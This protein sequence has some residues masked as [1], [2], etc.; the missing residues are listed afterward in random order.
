MDDRRKSAIP[1]RATSMSLLMNGAGSIVSPR[2]TTT[3]IKSFN[4]KRLS[5]AATA[6]PSKRVPTRAPES[7]LNQP[8][9]RQSL[10][11]PRIL[12]AYGLKSNCNNTVNMTV[13]KAV[14]KD[15]QERIK[16]CVRKRPTDFGEREI[17][18]LDTREQSVTVEC[19]KMG[20][21]GYSKSNGQMK[22][23]FDHVFDDRS[24]NETVPIRE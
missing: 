14:R 10:A 20:L 12:N 19:T 18:Q 24:S 23:F 16:V 8:A 3:T 2:K 4:V 9:R 11:T 17:V 22:F 15:G 7:P 13:K 6:S 21:D 5:D 1:T